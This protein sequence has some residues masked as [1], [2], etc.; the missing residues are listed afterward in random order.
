[1]RPTCCAPRRVFQARAILDVP[2]VKNGRMLA[3]LFIH[4]PEVR[5]W[6]P[7]DVAL[8]EETCERLW[9]AVE[10]GRA[11]AARSQI[12]EFNRRVLQASGDCIKVLDL[13]GRLEFMNDGGMR[14]I[15]VDDFGDLQGRIWPTT[16]KARTGKALFTP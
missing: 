14:V 8:V 13:E 12:E 6:T 7:N 9:S 16:G 2:L 11:Q 1:M 4:H 3:M 15:E 5:S 10:R